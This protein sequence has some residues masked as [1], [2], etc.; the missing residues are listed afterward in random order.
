MQ[1]LKPAHNTCQ[2]E[3]QEEGGGSAARVISLVLQASQAASDAKASIFPLRD[4]L[5]SVVSLVPVILFITDDSWEAL[6]VVTP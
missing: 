5:D 1:I 6:K 2:D 3:H 4:N